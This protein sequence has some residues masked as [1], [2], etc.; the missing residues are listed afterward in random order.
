[1]ADGKFHFS[2]G[3][4]LM[5]KT[6]LIFFSG[7]KDIVHDGKL[8]WVKKGE[9]RK[10]KFCRS[11]TLRDEVKETLLDLEKRGI[12]KKVAAPTEWISSMVLVAKPGKKR[13]CLEP[14]DLNKTLKRPK[15]QMPILEE[16]LPQLAKAKVFLTLDAKDGFDQ[17][18]L[19][20]ESSMKTAFWIENAIWS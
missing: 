15:Y 5:K 19:D 20:K 6:F 12:I 9:K 3:E 1:M 14:R 2:N 13:I 18:G 8:F 7:Q 4:I 17:I 10:V 11:G 16:I